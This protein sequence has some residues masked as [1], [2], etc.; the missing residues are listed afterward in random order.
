MRRAWMSL[1]LAG[2]AGSVA[3]EADVP[4]LQLAEFPAP[5]VSASRVDFG[6]VQIDTEAPPQT[7]TVR[8][9]NREPLKVDAF[10]AGAA[11]DD[12]GFTLEIPDS[13]T[14]TTHQLFHV[15][16]RFTPRER[17]RSQDAIVLR[18]E[19]AGRTKEMA[20]EL[21]GEGVESRFRVRPERVWFGNVLVGT[22]AWRTLELTNDSRFEAEIELRS[23][24]GLGLCGPRA[25]EPFCLQPFDRD[26]WDD[27]R[28]TMGPGE[29]MDMQ[30]RFRPLIANVRERG[31]LRLSHCPLSRC[32]LNVDIEGIGVDRG[33]VCEPSSLQFA[34]VNP[35][36]T[37]E[38]EVTCTNIA[39]VPVTVV[40]ASL[41]ED[42]STRFSLEPVPTTA[43]AA[44]THERAG[45]S[46]SIPVR[47]APEFLGRDDGRLEVFI[48]TEA[49][50]QESARID[51][52]GSGGGP[53]IQIEETLIMFGLTSLLAPSQRDVIIRNR[54]HSDLIIDGVIV[55]SLDTN[56][57]SS[58]QAGAT[59]IPPGGFEVLP[60]AF[61]P[62]SEGLVETRLRIHSNDPDQPQLDVL[63]RGEGTNLPPC[64]A[65]LDADHLDFGD[66]LVGRPAL[67]SLIIRNRS[68]SSPC[69]VTS[70]RL[71]RRIDERDAEFTL[72]HGELTSRIIPE[73]GALAVSVRYLPTSPGAHARTLFIELA[74]PE[75]PRIDVQLAG[76]AGTEPWLV[77]PNH[78]DFGAVEVGQPTF[79][80]RVTVEPMDIMV[81]GTVPTRAR[82]HS[83][84]LE[85]PS[86]AFELSSLPEL[87]LHVLAHEPLSFDVSFRGDRPSEYAARVVISGTFDGQPVR[88]VI[89]LV[90]RAARGALQ[91]DRFTQVGR[92]EVDVLFVAD[93]SGSPMDEI[94]GLLQQSDVFLAVADDF[95]VDFH[96]GVTTT[97]VDRIE[98]RLL[99]LCEPDC[100]RVI[101]SKSQP[102]PAEA[103]A[104]VLG[105]GT[106]GSATEQPLE[107]ARRALSAPHIDGHNAGFRRP[108]AGL[109]IIVIT[110][111]PDQSPR[112]PEFYHRFWSSFVGA[113]DPL[114]L[115]ISSVTGGLEGCSGPGGQ[116][117]YSRA[118]VALTERTGGVSLSICE[119]TWADHM[120]A[121]GEHAF[122]RRSR[123]F[124]TNPPV[125]STLS[126]SVDDV[127]LPAVEASGRRNWTFNAEHEA[128]DFSPLATPLPGANIRLEYVVETP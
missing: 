11:H 75:Q 115:S 120:R 56:A 127:P 90:G 16:V 17:G 18:F 91:A 126:V 52:R 43:L 41:T 106:T 70:V 60:I 42:S 3:C 32:D 92:S 68:D 82:I 97:D 85:D 13:S 25:D 123:F 88:W 9:V 39:N 38:R 89:S 31:R 105:V 46:V 64:H 59:V 4:V 30:V 84:A 110:N 6:A 93:D 98:G 53:D 8:S 14:L 87:P 128:V 107:G 118:I 122:G 33:F 116:A 114:A 36:Q 103:L 26:F 112:R 121:L 48:D 71:A 66:V 50:S 111:E 76:E 19:L 63:L 113:D 101:T 29:T 58:D 49:S 62:R 7:I 95:G 67:L 65:E 104:V 2:G 78:V 86:G 108:G 10:L 124:L 37:A 20:I 1:M 100:P 81:R 61:Q 125:I 77:T 27:E 99:M 35:G 21:T 51:L 44:A 12:G 72:P 102:S 94:S 5:R 23:A 45:G 47:Y 79:P 24:T 34:E 83:I 69:L 40:G 57:F 22:D 74:H 15:R 80:R 73:A 119:F 28:F 117:W 54:G 96:V 55:D 109:A